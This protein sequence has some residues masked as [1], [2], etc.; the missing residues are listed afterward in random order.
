MLFPEKNSE[1]NLWKRKL[2]KTVCGF[3]NWQKKIS[4]PSLY[5]ILSHASVG[6]MS[7]YTTFFPLTLKP[8]F[9][10]LHKLW[11][12]SVKFYA[13]WEKF[14]VKRMLMLASFRPGI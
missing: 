11:N 3:E 14:T 2:M 12:V 5:F 9:I 10:V 13:I 8:V 6:E 7:H 4:K 1:Q